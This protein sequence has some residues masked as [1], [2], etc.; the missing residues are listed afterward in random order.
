MRLTALKSIPDYVGEIPRGR[1]FVC[2][3]DEKAQS[4]IR[5]GY[6]EPVDPNPKPALDWCGETVFILASGP[7]LTMEQC[8]A[9]RGKGRVIAI[10]T[11]FRLA[12]WADVL[13]ACD[14]EWWA[15]YYEEAK[16]CTG[17]LWTQSVGHVKRDGLNVVQARRSPGLSKDQTIHLGNGPSNS[18]YQAIGLAHLAGAKRIILLGYD[19]KAGKK[20]HHHGDHPRHLNKSLPFKAWIPQFDQLAKD[21]QEAGV[22]VLNATPGSALTCLPQVSLDEC[23]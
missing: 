16:A 14:S 22:E 9:V 20:K 2:L 19:M 3:D 23:L 10:N 12:P 21:L 7:S 5:Q 4:L 13:Y 15:E 1:I 11:T 8:E 17:Q 18:G 6:A